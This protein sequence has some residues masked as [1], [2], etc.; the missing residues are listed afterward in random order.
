M[1][2]KFYPAISGIKITKSF[3]GNR[4]I[5]SF[6]YVNWGEASKSNYCFLSAG[7]DI[8]N[9]NLIKGVLFF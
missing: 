8:F 9:N 4:F 2:V 5:P 7:V 1:S 6:H 3:N